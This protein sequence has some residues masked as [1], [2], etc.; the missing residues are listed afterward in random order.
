MV[1]MPAASKL[2]SSI[3]WQ[4]VSSSQA[5]Q[6]LLKTFRFTDWIERREFFKVWAA[7][8]SFQIVSGSISVIICRCVMFPQINSTSKCFDLLP[9]KK[10]CGLFVLYWWKGQIRIVF[11]FLLFSLQQYFVRKG[12]SIKKLI[13]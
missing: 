3:F 11:C 9:D 6:T 7:N 8:S 1:Q 2:E 5:I 10:C 13:Q 4:R 12:F